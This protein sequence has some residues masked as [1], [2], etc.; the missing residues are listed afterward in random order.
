MKE[1]KTKPIMKGEYCRKHDIL[2]C[3]ICWPRTCPKDE[4]REIERTED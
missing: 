2:C 1:E 4:K 3:P